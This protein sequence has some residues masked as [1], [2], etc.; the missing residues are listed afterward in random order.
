MNS[1]NSTVAAQGKEVERLQRENQKLQGEI[2][3]HRITVST[4]TSC[5]CR[6]AA[7]SVI[8]Y[9]HVSQARTQVDKEVTYWLEQGL[10]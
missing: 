9:I 2:E 7:T 10:S 5:T 6:Y 4:I 8:V 3:T 1:L